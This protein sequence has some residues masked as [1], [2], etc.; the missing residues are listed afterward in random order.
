MTERASQRSVAVMGLAFVVLLIATFFA[1][2]ATPNAHADV[3]KVV[4]F[5]HDNKTIEIVN[6]YLTE[7]SV[8]VGITFFW[9]LRER[10]VAW[11]ATL[12]FAGG[13][14]LGVSGGLAA[15]LEACLTDGV[16][17]VS[18]VAM[19]ALNVARNDLVEF[20]GSIGGAI[21]LFAASAAI[22]QGGKLPRW[23][24]WAG[25]VLGVVSL[26][27]PGLGALGVGL[28]VLVASI[29]MLLEPAASDA[30]ATP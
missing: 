4:T 30:P 22:L 25:I 1:T 10:L 27:I 23:L 26:V 13:V 24:A 29:L 18:P 12:A 8:V 15:G 20:L 19:Q 6:A 28:W 11:S 5:Y 3:A 7:L 21:F 9:F 14:V 2:P 17:H 16:N